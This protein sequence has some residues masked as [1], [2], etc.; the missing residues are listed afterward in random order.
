LR[1]I[2]VESVHGHGCVVCKYGISSRASESHVSGSHN[3]NEY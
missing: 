3:T 2:G 1:R